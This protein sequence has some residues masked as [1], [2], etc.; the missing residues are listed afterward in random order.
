[1][2]VLVVDDSLLFMKFVSTVVKREGHEVLEAENGVEGYEL[3]EK[4]EPDLIFTDIQMPKLNGLELLKKVRKR[5]ADTIVVVITAFDSENY[6]VDALRLGAQ[7]YLRKPFPIEDLTGILHKYAEVVANRTLEREIMGMIHERQIKMKIDNRID[8]TPNIAVF[9]LRE[10]ADTISRADWLGVQLGLTELLMNAIEHGNLGISFEEKRK[11]F[12][13]S[14]EGLKQLYEERLSDPVIAG[15]LVTVDFKLDE[16]GCEWVIT[17]S[18]QGFD[19]T[20]IPN[21]LEKEEMERP[22]GRGIFIS[23]FQFDEM[24]YIGSG[25]TVRVKKY[26]RS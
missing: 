25:N 10:T 14:P 3:F 21:P 17:D 6:V 2:K 5:S 15:R 23:R 8:L 19:W 24:E 12:S 20:T 16:T 1:M 26:R 22:L 13:S 9:L 7:N 4:F 11:A 18:G